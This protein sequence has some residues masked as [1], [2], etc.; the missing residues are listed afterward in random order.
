MPS[1]PEIV[2]GQLQEN[3]ENRYDGYKKIMQADIVKEIPAN[4]WDE[5]ILQVFKE[6]IYLY[7]TGNTTKEDLY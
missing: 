4:S 1:S 6:N 5:K 7:L 3:N 2:I